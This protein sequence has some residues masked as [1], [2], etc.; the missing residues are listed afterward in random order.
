MKA[1][2]LCDVKGSGKKGDIVNVSDGYF[3]NFLL[4]N[5]KAIAA[6]NN[7]VNMAVQKKSSENFHEEER[8]KAAL[9]LAEKMKGLEINFSLKK[10]ANGKAFGSISTKEIVDGLKSKDYNVDKKQIVLSDNIKT[11]GIF[12][13]T[14]KLYPKI[15]TTIKIIVSVI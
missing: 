4:P 12:N 14:I 8:R 2:L 3:K 7:S 1:I 13:V 11:E 10:G 5:K 9:A 6:D 15:N